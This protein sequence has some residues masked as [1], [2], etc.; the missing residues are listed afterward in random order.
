VQLD[1]VLG[2]PSERA[3]TSG[4]A[5]ERYR[6]AAA[7]MQADGP[8]TPVAVHAALQEALLRLHSCTLPPPFK[9][10]LPPQQAKM[11]RD[12]GLPEDCIEETS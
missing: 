5:Q 7:A 12:L 8:M 9:M 6:Q 10:L 2:L 4:V 1:S 3:V 11:W